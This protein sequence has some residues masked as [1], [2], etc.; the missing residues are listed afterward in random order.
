MGLYPRFDP[1]ADMQDLSRVSGLK[2]QWSKAVSHWFDGTVKAEAGRY[3]AAGVK[4][5][6]QYFNPVTLLPDGPHVEQ[7]ITWNA[8]PKELL[9]QYGRERAL[10][11]ADTLWTLDRY[12]SLAVG[13][14]CRR[15][16]Y[17]PHN[18]YCEWHVFRDPSTGNIKRVVFVSEPPEYY[19]A[20]WGGWVEG[21]H[22]DGDPSV[23]L[24]LYREFVST[25]VQLKDLVASEDINVGGLLAKK[26][27]YNPYNKWNTTHG[28]MH[29][30]SP[31]NTLMAEIQLGGDA[32]VVRMTDDQHLLVEPDVLI[33]S[34]GYGGPD[35]NSDPTIGG[36][37]NAL[38]RL[39]AR[40]TLKNPVGLYMDHIDLAG[41]SAPDGGSVSDLVKIVRGTLGSI[42]RLEVEVPVERGFTLSNIAIG[43]EPIR[44]GGQIAE[45][46][47]VKLVAVAIMA[48]VKPT[49]LKWSTHSF[50]DPAF[51]IVLGRA[52]K[53][54][55]PAPPG[56]V[57]ALVGQ[58]EGTVMTSTQAQAAA[59]SQAAFEPELT[60]TRRP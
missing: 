24:D 58:G 47:T 2:E 7:A 57:E 40:T 6:V 60:L 13:Q 41:W 49:P 43:G 11:E 59:G 53:I 33:C 3:K 28:I 12:S 8:F 35:R 34:T 22:F 39:G 31:P 14:V 20:L 19:R 9:R 46:I 42:E 10:I 50:I 17:R 25:E 48:E 1:P 38:A 16:F 51:P 54:G 29:L 5:N 21:F 23:V 27:S 36:T 37:V 30:C 45:C 26:G 56:Y 44:Y 55:K 15:T 52:E 18:E 32:S 4:E